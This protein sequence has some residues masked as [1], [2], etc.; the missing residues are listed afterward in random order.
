VKLEVGDR[1]LRVGSDPPRYGDVVERYHGRPSATDPGV[2]FYAVRWDDTATVERHYM[3][4]GLIRILR[5]T[6]TLGV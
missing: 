5:V 3:E 4:I 6:R 1:V 2:V